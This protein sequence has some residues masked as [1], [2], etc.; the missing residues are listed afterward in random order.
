[1]KKKQIVCLLF[2]F[3]ALVLSIPGAAIAQDT[4]Y[5][6]NNITI[7]LGSDE[8]ELNFS[9]LTTDSNASELVVCSEDDL[10]DGECPES[11][12]T[13]YV[14]VVEEVIEEKSS[15][16][17][18]G[19]P[20]GG[21]GGP[22]GGGSSDTDGDGVYDMNDQC[23][24]TPEGDTVNED[25]CTDTDQDGVADTD[26]ACEDT[27][28]GTVVDE[29]GCPLADDADGD[30]VLNDV[31]E[32][33]DTELGTT[34]NA[35]GCPDEDGDGVADD[36]D[37]CLGTSSGEEVDENGCVPPVYACKVTMTDV[38]MGATYAYTVGYGDTFT[39]IDTFTTKDSKH[40]N[41]I[42]V[43]D[44]QIGA[45]SEDTDAEGW[46][47]TVT[48]ALT[49]F[50]DTSFILS[51]GDQVEKATSDSQYEGFFSA[52]E[53]TSVPFAPTNGNHDTSVLYSYHFNVPNESDYGGLESES[54][55]GDILYYGGDY[56]FTFGKALFM[57]LNTNNSSA[58]SHSTFMEEAI[59]ANTDAAWKVVVFHHSLYSSARHVDDVDDLRTSLVPVMDEHDIDIVLSGHDHF[60]ARSYPLTDFEVAEDNS[61]VDENGRVVD[62]DGTVYFTADSASGSKYYPFTY[63]EGYTNYYLA[64]YSQPNVPS[65]LNVEVEELAYG[66]TFT[67]SA[68]ITETGEEIDTYTILKKDYDL[69]GDGV[70]DRN[71]V[72]VIRSF[73]RQPASVNPAADVDNDGTITIRDA[74]KLMTMFTN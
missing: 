33:D 72:R 66:D 24:D 50:E 1:M 38:E 7:Q 69:N 53:L 67:V 65:Y 11:A 46:A 31:D 60:Y 39:D 22:P 36:D 44:P 5:E 35:Q 43:G 9:W 73:L 47:T 10:A 55:E 21:P 45:G 17:G 71:D 20:S 3:A 28:V 29:N 52:E 34:V 70:I 27:P 74:R 63:T 57:V 54:E 18:G 62:P 15:G 41:F 64:A 61:N 14:A 30:G 8:T 13:T 42:F 32:C 58:A 49:K 59:N 51:A 68:Y 16:N 56:W 25:G 48:A 6:A 12:A 37:Q 4:E 40:Y 26:D 19:P 2:L 23:E